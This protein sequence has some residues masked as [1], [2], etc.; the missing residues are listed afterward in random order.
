VLVLWISPRRFRQ[1][2]GLACLAGL[3]SLWFSLGAAESMAQAPAA[4]ESPVATVTLG[5]RPL[6]TLQARQSADSVAERAQRMSARLT[7]IA[8]DQ[9]LAVEAIALAPTEFGTAIYVEENLI[10]T[11]TPEDTVGTD[12]TTEALAERHLAVI[13]TEIAAYRAV[14]SAE[15][16]ARA[17]A[18]AVLC[19]LGLVLL[20]VILANLMPQIYRWLDR[21]QDRWVPNVRIQNFELLTAAQLTTLIEGITKLLHFGLVSALVL[22]YLSYVL[23]LFPQT[24]PLGQGLFGHLWGMVQGTW[25]GFID[26]L[27][28]LL[29]IAIILFVARCLMRFARWIFV[30]IGQR[31][32]TITGFYPEWATPTYRLVQVVIIAIAFAVIFPYLP[33]A[34]SPAFQG[35]SIFFGL[36]VSLGAGGVV[37]SIVSGFILVYTRAFREGDRIQLGSIDGFVVEKSLLVTRLRTLENVLVSIPN[38]ELLTNNI[39]NY[40]AL[41]REQQTPVILTTTLTLGYDV[42]WPQVHATLIAA[43]NATAHI[44]PTPPPQVW[45]TSLDDFYV[46]YQLRAHTLYP[47]QLETI[48]SELHQNLQDHCNRAGIEIMSPHYRAIRDGNHPAMPP[49]AGLSN[50]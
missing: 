40:S 37:F 38:G 18:L 44:L 26:Y 31:R 43:A 3:L 17:V 28:N 49:R 14:R 15:Y 30:N 4:A 50:A 23:S 34:N 47:E 13:Q 9:S 2:L 27:P 19:T 33:G 21:Q 6:F 20:L 22:L 8:Q 29:S 11:V 39:T 48:Y 1:G 41:V 46:S 12:L 25:A 35:V 24:Q 32:L 5:D 42:P 7:A 10:M 36:L 16:L 45:Q